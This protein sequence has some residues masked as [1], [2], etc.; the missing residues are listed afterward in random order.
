MEFFVLSEA[1]RVFGLRD[2][3]ALHLIGTFNMCLH[4]YHE[5]RGCDSG[6]PFRPTR[7]RVVKMHMASWHRIIIERSLEMRSVRYRLIRLNGFSSSHVTFVRESS[8]IRTFQIFVIAFVS[9]A[10]SNSDHQSIVLHER[11]LSFERINLFL[12]E[13]SK[14][15]VLFPL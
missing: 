10:F 3:L 11:V 2:D 8:K 6:E 12:C 4:V 7:R 14:K 13:A 9:N 1:G 5:S 15:F